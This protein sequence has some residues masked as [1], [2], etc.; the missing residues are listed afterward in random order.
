MGCDM[1]TCHTKFTQKQLKSILSYIYMECVII[2]DSLPI[3]IFIEGSERLHVQRSRCNISVHLQ[4][5]LLRQ[6]YGISTTDSGRAYRQCCRAVVSWTAPGSDVQSIAK[7]RKADAT[8]IVPV[9][10]LQHHGQ[11]QSSWTLQQNTSTMDSS[12]DQRVRP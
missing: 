1:S 3:F 5:D 11:R 4:L 12:M 8:K 9:P 10:Q 2:I 7:Y 6:L